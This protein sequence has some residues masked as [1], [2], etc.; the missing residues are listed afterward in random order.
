MVE[1]GAKLNWAL[2]EGGAVDKILLYFAPKILGG[3]DSLPMVGGAG[4]RSRSGAIR[5][6]N[7]RTRPVGPDEFLVE[8]TVVN[9]NVSPGD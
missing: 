9:D 5:V 3:F 7:L 1:G 6:R 8:A 4:R 2:L